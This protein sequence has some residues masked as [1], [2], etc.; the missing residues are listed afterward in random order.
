METYKYIDNQYFKRGTLIEVHLADIHFGA[1][2]PKTQYGIL[3]EQFFDRIVKLPKIDIISI[4]GDLFDHKVMSNSDATMCAVN[5]ITNLVHWCSMNN[6]TLVILAGTYSHDFDQLK[7]FYHF[8][9]DK[10]NFGADVRVITQMQFEIIKGARILMIP[11]LNG[12]NESVY[13]KFFFESGYYDEAFVHGT[14]E[15]SVYGNLTSGSSRLLTAKDFCYC[16]GVAISGHVHKAGCFQGFYYYCGSPYR[17][18]FGE[19]EEKGFLILAHDLDTQIHYVDFQPLKSFRYDT[20]YLDELVSEDPKKICDY[21]NNRRINE[22]IDYIKVKF[23]VPIPGYNKTIINN[24]YRNNPTTFVEFL[25]QDEI[26]KKKQEEVIK[27]TKYDYLIDNS[28][29]DFDRFVRYVNDSEGCEFLT[30]QKLTELLNEK[31]I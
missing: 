3:M 7:L 15:G 14:F 24:Y 20:I 17:W 2:D 30:V 11:E 19:E 6:T 22:G 26:E 28:I 4:D 12:V 29:S 5:F 13:R 18:K 16:K 10:T 31:I 27:N 25:A 1:F 9:D 8:M 21:I 23:R